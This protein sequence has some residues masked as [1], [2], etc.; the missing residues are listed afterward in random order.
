MLVFDVA[1]LALHSLFHPIIQRTHRPA[2]AH[3]LGRNALAN[4]ALRTAILDQ[5]FGRPR[6][7]VDEAGRDG[8]ALRVDHGRRLV[9]RKSPQPHDPIAAKGNVGNARLFARAVVN[10]PAFDDDVEFVGGRFQA[11]RQGRERE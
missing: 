2:F 8:Q 9:R 11:R 3:D 4:F 5:R 6:E 10:G 1:L 7:H